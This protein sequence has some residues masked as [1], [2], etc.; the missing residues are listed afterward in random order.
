M[1]AR[2]QKA[3][4][5]SIVDDD[6]SFRDA[7][8]RLVKSLGYAAHTFASAEDFLQSGRIDDTA[9]LILDVNMPG[10][11]GIALQNHLHAQ[12]NLTPIIFVTAHPGAAIQAQA[13]K[14]GAVGFLS[15]PIKEE[16]LI[17]HLDMALKS[18]KDDGAKR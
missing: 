4:M 2:L 16:C 13:L 1:M 5:I 6:E 17:N 11:S 18:H 7:A 15:K 8:G 12:G 3:P 10:V 9:C 14:G